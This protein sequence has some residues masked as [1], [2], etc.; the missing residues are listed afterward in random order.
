[1]PGFEVK[2]KT[3]WEINR[4]RFTWTPRRDGVA[5][6]GEGAPTDLK[7]LSE[8]LVECLGHKNYDVRGSAAL[9]LGKAGSR[10]KDTAVPALEKLTKDRHWVA[11]ESA[12][13]ALGMLGAKTSVPRLL[14]ILKDKKEKNRLRAHG[15]VALGL[16]GEKSAARTMI[17]LLKRP[18]VDEQV[19]ASCMLGL[20]LMKEES[21]ALTLLG[22]MT[23]RSEKEDLRAMAATALGKMGFTQVRS[24]RR[25]VDVVQE[26]VR[27]LASGKKEKKLKLSAI[28]AVSALG[29]SEKVS[30]DKLVDTLGR[31][32]TKRSNADVRSFILLAIA[33]L[34]CD[35]P[36]LNRARILVRNVLRAESNGDLLSFACIAAGLSKDRDAIRF[37]RDVFKKKSNPEVRSAA[38]VSLGLL[39]DVAS[40]E[41]LLA[42]ISGKGAPELKGYCC[43]ALGLMGVKDNMEALPKLRDILEN[44]H[45]PELRAAAAMGLTLLG[46]T[47]AV[48][49]LMKAVDEGNTYIRKTI[50]MGVG[51][52][53]DVSTVK[54]LTELYGKKRGVNDATRAIIVTALGYITEEAEMPILKKLATHYNHLLFK[55]DA[56]LQMVKLL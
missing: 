28:M 19:K 12:V 37:V 56:L 49:I 47:G 36:A 51:F 9:A 39:K 55:Y 41:L 31:L 26:L 46:D 33:E 54:A 8:F 23:R 6:N 53:R 32:Y 11:S 4:W 16:I 3:W 44:G 21:A 5:T 50:I 24:G 1:M 2:W 15:A 34:G 13:L 18:K 30:A 29:P 40:T 17:D 7:F 48:K 35:G 25:K 27:V 45:I 52:F 20:A 22:F 14:E 42:T 38:A 10:F 43:I